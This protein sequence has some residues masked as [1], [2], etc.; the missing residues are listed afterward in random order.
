MHAHSML[1]YNCAASCTMAVVVIYL[2]ALS[3]MEKLQ[4][5]LRVVC[6]GLGQVALLAAGDA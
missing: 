5:C 1:L 3:I 6:L 4:C 2:D